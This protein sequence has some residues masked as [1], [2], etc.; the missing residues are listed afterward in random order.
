MPEARFKAIT[1][2]ILSVSVVVGILVPNIGE[3]CVCG[4]VGLS[5]RRWAP[6]RAP[7]QKMPVKSVED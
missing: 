1:V 4:G 2:G 7:Y 6:S 5:P 3:W